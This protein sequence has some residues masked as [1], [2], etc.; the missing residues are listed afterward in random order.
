MLIFYYSLDYN[1]YVDAF[2]NLFD[3][4]LK[5]L[6]IYWNFCSKLV[7][8]LVCRL[9]GEDGNWQLGWLL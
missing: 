8:V 4:I 5:V 7:L 9:E 1:D 6:F 2:R 3:F